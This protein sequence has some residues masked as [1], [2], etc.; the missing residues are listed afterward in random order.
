MNNVKLVELLGS[1]SNP[2][3][4][5][6]LIHE[7]DRSVVNVAFDLYS[8]PDSEFRFR[9]TKVLDYYS[10]RYNLVKNR[11]QSLWNTRDCQLINSN[12]FLGDLF[13]ILES[14]TKEDT[15]PEIIFNFG[16]SIGLAWLSEFKKNDMSQEISTK[17]YELLNIFSKVLQKL[18]P[19]DGLHLTEVASDSITTPFL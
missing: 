8:N 5:V 10:I 9:Y 4:L 7:L 12:E 2:A 6:T 18:L 19:K 1:F 13:L 14:L 16:K 15:D 11:H 17:R 3:Q